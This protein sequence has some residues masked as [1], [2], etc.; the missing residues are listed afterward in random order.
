MKK[1][2]MPRTELAEVL[3]SFRK[4]FYTA[5]LFSMFINVLGLVPSIY[6]LQV[7]DRV[8]QSRNITTLLMITGIMIVFYVMLGMLE[9]VRSKLLIRVGAQLD[10][11]LNDRVFV[12]SFEK[13]LKRAGGNPGQALSDLKIGRA[14]CRERVFRAV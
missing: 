1:A 2:M 4:A 12:A 3:F 7:Y 11:K 6:M 14:S 10:L 9:V 5:G 8:L 13:N